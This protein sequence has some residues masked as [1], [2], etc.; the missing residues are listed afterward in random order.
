MAA[1]F[2]FCRDGFGVDGARPMSERRNKIKNSKVNDE[3]L[4]IEI[5]P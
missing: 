5:A 4:K 2:D 3:I 1:E